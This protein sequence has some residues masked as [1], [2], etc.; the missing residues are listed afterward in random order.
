[1]VVLDKYTHCALVTAVSNNNN[2]TNNNNNNNN[3][4][5]SFL[6]V[7]FKEEAEMFKFNTLQL[8]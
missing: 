2:N 7:M 1:M 3:N 5:N 6:F 8:I 4:N